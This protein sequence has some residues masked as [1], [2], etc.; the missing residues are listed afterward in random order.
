MSPDQ[1][2]PPEPDNLN[3]QP[4]NSSP[5]SPSPQ[6]ENV[7]S[8]QTTPQPSSIPSAVKKKSSQSTT[9]FQAQLQQFWRT[10]QPILKSQS[11]KALKGSI[12][13]LEGAVEKLEEPSSSQKSQPPASQSLPPNRYSSPADAT[14]EAAIAPADTEPTA[15]E[16]ET[17]PAT[18]SP[19][20][21]KQPATSES[22]PKSTST[23]P[24]ST[25]PIAERLHLREWKEKLQPVWERA[26]VWWA[27]L[28]EKIR[29]FLP[30]TWNEKLS[31]PVLGS[32]VAGI[33][34]LVLWI[35]SGLFSSPSSQVATTPTSRRTPPPDLKAPAELAAPEPKASAT[36]RP[37]PTPKPTAIASPTPSASPNV[38]ASPTPS[39]SIVA[40]PTPKPKVIAQKPKAPPPKLDL[41]PEQSLIAAIQ[42]QVAEIT[43]QYA[44]GLIQSIQAN[45][46]GS[47]L[48]VQVGE[49]WYELSRDRQNKLANEM[50]ERAQ[51]LDFS[52]LEITSTQGNLLARSPVV[53]T[54]MVILQ[55]RAAL[56]EENRV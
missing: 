24:T 34:V 56:T 51:E 3:A 37:T 45:F 29:S 47:R 35:M 33:L 12:Q 30:E 55:R 4:P 41:T 18:P 11:I 19:A 38:A 31:N 22:V 42:D 1:P 39:P 36:P 26:K 25:Q 23:P 44:N 13:L 50:L 15:A 49:D 14:T 52:K 2:N 48:I 32:I 20:P 10:A 53:G 9:D 27:F 43:N 17:K 46:R 21:S 54:Q 40:S 5:E 8:S 6:E 7:G 16:T 28:L